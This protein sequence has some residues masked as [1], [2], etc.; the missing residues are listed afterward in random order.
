MPAFKY[1][2]RNG[3]K[4]TTAGHDTLEDAG[5]DLLKRYSIMELVKVYDPLEGDFY[6]I[7]R[8][9]DENHSNDG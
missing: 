3:D 9:R 1:E 4:G 5:N 2:L 6:Q 8:G 7:Q